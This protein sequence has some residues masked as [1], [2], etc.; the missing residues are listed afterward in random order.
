MVYKI[1]VYLIPMI[2]MWIILFVYYKFFKLDEKEYDRI[3]KV[4]EERKIKNEK[5]KISQDIFAC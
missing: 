5:W 3:L 1:L 4:I 2:L